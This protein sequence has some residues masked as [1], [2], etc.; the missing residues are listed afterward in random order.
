MLE[1]STPPGSRQRCNTEMVIMNRNRDGSVCTRS[2]SVINILAATVE[3]KY[4]SSVVE[5]WFH[6]VVLFGAHAM[7][8]PNIDRA[9]IAF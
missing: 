2:S 3:N 6:R 4:A 5:S 8:C 1:S 7:L 9:R